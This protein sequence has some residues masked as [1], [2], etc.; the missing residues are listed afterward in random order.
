LLTALIKQ[1]G[2]AGVRLDSLESRVDVIEEKAV[3]DSSKLT[4]GPSMPE[5][6]LPEVKLPS[7]V[8]M[9]NFWSSHF[10]SFRIIN[11]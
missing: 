9:G 6:K 2:A 1:V 4:A 8:S 10:Y 11:S 7:W 5:A 3:A